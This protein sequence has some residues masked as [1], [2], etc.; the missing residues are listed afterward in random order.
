MAEVEQSGTQFAFS[1]SKPG[2]YYLSY[3]DDETYDSF[4]QK[5]DVEY[6]GQIIDLAFRPVRTQILRF[7]IASSSPDIPF[8]PESAKLSITVKSGSETIFTAEVIDKYIEFS[9]SSASHLLNISQSYTVQVES[10]TKS[11][12]PYSSTF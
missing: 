9:S 1:V 2:K 6:S 8:V 10:G 11:F 3:V 12:A 7:Y 4:T 5:I